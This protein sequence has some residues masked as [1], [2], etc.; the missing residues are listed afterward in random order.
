MAFLK[1]RSKINKIKDGIVSSI[2]DDQ[3]G[4]CKITFIIISQS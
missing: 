1:A 2:M 3:N 4:R